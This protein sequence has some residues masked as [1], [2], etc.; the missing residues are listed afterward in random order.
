MAMFLWAYINIQSVD[1]N[2]WVAALLCTV[3]NVDWAPLYAHQ[4][5]RWA[6]DFIADCE[7]LPQN[8]YGG[9]N[10]SLIDTDETLAQDI[11]L[12]LQGIWKFVKSMDLVDFLDTPEMWEW[13]GLT[14]WIHLTTAQRWMKKLD[15][16]WQRDLKGQ[17]VDGHEHE[18]VVNYHQKVYLLS[19]SKIKPKT[20]HRWTS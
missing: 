1:H 16:C 14:K 7:V 13:T 19:W 3:S 9:W 4:L 10:E 15:C 6:C 17:F 11:H 20:G 8:P 18:D 2:K 5:H 12:H